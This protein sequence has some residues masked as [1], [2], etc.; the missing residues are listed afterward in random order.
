[1]SLLIFDVDHGFAALARAE[2]GVPYL[3]DCGHSAVTGFRPSSYLASQGYTSLGR[4]VVSHPDE[5]HLSDLPW[6]ISRRFTPSLLHYNRTTS[7]SQI[8]QIKRES[9]P[10]QPGVSAFLALARE[11][12]V[13]EQAVT[14]APSSPGIR[15]TVFHNEFPQFRD[16]NNLSL[17]SFVETDGHCVVLPGDLEVA[18]WRAL[19]LQ[20]MFRALLA[21]V[22]VF[23]ASHHGRESG[24]CQEVFTHCRPRVVIVSDGPIQYD[25]QRVPYADHA[26]GVLWEDGRTRRVLTTRN[27]GH[28]HLT[29]RNGIPFILAGAR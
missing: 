25:S 22:T 28:I 12:T 21:R 26:Q 20:P 9:G 16:T 19:L 11:Y 15:L 2:N 3:F 8:E 17:V 10:I 5:D 23:V 27:D 6:L 14:W 13:P 4:L 24:Y 29:N 7:P 18:G 1:M